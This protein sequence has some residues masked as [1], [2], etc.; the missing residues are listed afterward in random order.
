M[1]IKQT[2]FELEEVLKQLASAEPN[3]KYPVVDKKKRDELY[4][5]IYKTGVKASTLIGTSFFEHASELKEVQL[6][7]G[8]LSRADR[9]NRA[10]VYRETSHQV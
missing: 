6:D 3:C 2:Q 1:L 4:G 8:Q 9:P 5:K 10:A 7:K